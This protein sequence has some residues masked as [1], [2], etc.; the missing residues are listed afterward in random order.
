MAL[1]ILAGWR[2]AKGAG[3]GGGEAGVE[4]GNN[5]RGM[6]VT[7]ACLAD[8]NA[9]NW[10]GNT[11][12]HMAV[13]YGLAEC[14]AVLLDHGA[15]V[16]VKNAAGHPAIRGIHGTLGEPSASKRLPGWGRRLGP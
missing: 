12:L 9:Q 13:E 14:K 8:P 15:R 16:D 7:M 3:G 4:G 6:L 2:R 5:N 1:P 11:A 10:K